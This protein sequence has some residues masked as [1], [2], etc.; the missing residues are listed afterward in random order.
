KETGEVVLV[1]PL[2]VNEVPSYA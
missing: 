2:E 1:R